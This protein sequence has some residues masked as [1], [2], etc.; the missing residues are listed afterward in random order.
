MKLWRGIIDTQRYEKKSQ[1][2]NLLS[3]LD[4]CKNY[5]TIKS[6]GYG[7]D[8]CLY[9][10]NN[11]LPCQSQ[12]ISNYYINNNSNLIMLL[13]ELAPKTI[14]NIIDKN[15]VA[16]IMCHS[17]YDHEKI[18]SPLKIYP[19]FYKNATIFNL[20]ILAFIQKELNIKY[21]P[22]LSK[23][24]NNDLSVVA[25]LINN[26]SKK[27]DWMNKLEKISR[28]GYMPSMLQHVINTEYIKEDIS[29]FKKAID[30]YRL[31]EKQKELLNDLNKIHDVGY[32]YGLKITVV[33]SYMLFAIIFVFVFIKI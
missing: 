15:I 6:N 31:L 24:I 11:F 29:G 5:L 27:I 19:E 3:S 26:N 7:F 20:S 17:N 21:L 1:V 9:E 30:K 18:V 4:D 33:I 32:R 10:L 8:R 23:A 25:D 12:I 14:N 16:F 2:N 22:N 13:E 28:S